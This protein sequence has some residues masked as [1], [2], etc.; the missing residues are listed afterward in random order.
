MHKDIILVR[1]VRALFLFISIPNIS[2]IG[3]HTD[4]FEK[5]IGSLRILP[6]SHN[7]WLCQ[8]K[9]TMSPSSASLLFEN[10]ESAHILIPSGLNVVD[11]QVRGYV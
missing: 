6:V 4:R 10:E 5:V 2:S 11:R 3:H 8:P 7:H 9:L 1:L